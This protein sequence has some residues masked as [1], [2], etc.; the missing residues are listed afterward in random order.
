MSKSLGN[1]PDPLDLIK[2]YGADGVRTGMLFSSPAGND[3]LFDEKLVEQGRNFANKIWNAFR[4]VKGWET[5]TEA[6]PEV[7]KL[8]ID[9]IENR[10][11]QAKAELEDH[12]SKYRLSDALMTSYKLVWNDFC[13]WYLE[14]IKPAY[15]QPIDQAT[16][17]KTLELFESVVKLLHPFMPFIT[18]EIWQNISERST[19]ESL[20]VSSWPETKASDA[21]V[22]EEGELLFEI[23]S[24]I[25]N[26]RSSKG[27]SPKEELELAVKTD[28]P[29]L[30][31][32]I[33]SSIAKLANVSKLDIIDEKPDNCFSFVVKS[34]ELFVPVSEEIDVEA[35]R[36]KLTEE[37]NYTKGFLKSVEKKLSNERFVAGAPEQ[38]V[39]MEKKKQADAEAKIASLEASL[40][41]LG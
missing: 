36:A 15:E 31:K 13:S 1:S 10:F 35:E 34:H 11:N 14:W 32:K 4:L 6:Q 25:R 9:W 30:I 40:A 24:N 27:I 38:V 2:E 7:N 5:S 28:K 3:L 41:S 20:I 39:A 21:Q 22:L 33:G 37:L 8:A 16:Y 18:E 23:T 17:D 19:E 12:F 26:L 29:E